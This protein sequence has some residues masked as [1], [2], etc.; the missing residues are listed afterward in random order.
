MVWRKQEVEAIDGARVRDANFADERLSDAKCATC[1]QLGFCRIQPK[2]SCILCERAGPDEYCDLLEMCFRIQGDECVAQF[3]GASE[4]AALTGYLGPQQRVIGAS[5]SREASLS[6][7]LWKLGSS[8]ISSSFLMPT[9][10]V[11]PTPP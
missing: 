2:D 5:S 4:T 3:D 9:M 1:D 11:V 7:L 10:S 6:K 8:A